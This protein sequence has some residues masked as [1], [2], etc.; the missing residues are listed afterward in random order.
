MPNTAA[1]NA[2]VEM[3]DQFSGA[4]ARLVGKMKARAVFLS[5]AGEPYRI[6]RRDELERT[7]EL[8]TEELGEWL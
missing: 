4:V 5:E 1:D 8:V 7:I 2:R 6:G 3:G